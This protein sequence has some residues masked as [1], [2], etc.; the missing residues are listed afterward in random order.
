M[1]TAIVNE[2]SFE[3]NAPCEVHTVTWNGRTFRAGSM[4]LAALF[5]LQ[6]WLDRHHPGWYVYVIQGAYNVGVEQSAGTHDRDGCVDILILHRRTGRRLW[7][8]AL[9]WIR[10]RHF[11]GWLRNTGTW[12]NP[13]S[14]HFHI[15]VAGIEYTGCPVGI[16]VPGQIADAKAGRSGLVGHILDR[17]WRPKVYTP[18]P[19]RQWVERHQ[20]ENMPLN[21][22]DLAKVAEI[23]DKAV[24]KAWQR[25]QPNGRTRANNI[26]ETAKRV[27]VKALQK[28]VK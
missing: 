21:D 26:L 19:Y 20:E 8:R 5:A 4:L 6:E 23:V 27:G 17:T 11:Y 28:A 16:Y 15:I 24:E 7:L 25:K 18:F 14:W 12:L 10:R 13:S 2:V 9:P 22:E 1:A 3:S